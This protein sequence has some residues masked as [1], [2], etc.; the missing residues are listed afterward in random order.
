MYRQFV[1]LLAATIILGGLRALSAQVSISGEPTALATY[2]PRPQY[3]QEAREK[4]IT[5]R[6]VAVV[7]VDPRT[8]EVNSARI[9]SSTG[10]K[11]L[12]DAALAAF[13]QWRFKPGGVSK[14]KIPIRFVMDDAPGNGS[15][16][17]EVDQNTGRVT[18]VQMLASTG[19]QKLDD[20]ALNAFR[21]WR[22]KPG[23]PRKVKIPITFTMQDM[24]Y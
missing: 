7:S 15:L 4:R 2:A 10:H 1:R 21:K 19:N 14:V 5:G 22:F 9:E 13:R 18:S 6:G 24:R 23:G 17:A 16:L 20:A 3:P 8:G 11:I 12:D